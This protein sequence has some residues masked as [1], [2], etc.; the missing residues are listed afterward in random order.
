M[1]YKNCSRIDLEFYGIKIKPGETKWFPG[2]VTCANVVP[3]QA[4]TKSKTQS[5]SKSV[6]RKTT[7]KSKPKV[8]IVEEESVLNEITTDVDNIDKVNTDMSD[9]N[10]EGVEEDGKHSN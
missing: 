3:V 10:N 5:K 8:E 9:I 2:Y 6:F 7:K 4:E 1:R